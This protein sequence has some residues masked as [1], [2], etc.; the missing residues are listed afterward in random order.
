V[1]VPVKCWRV[2]GLGLGL[3]SVAWPG[4]AAVSTY[5][6]EAT[7][8]ELTGQFTPREAQLTL[9]RVVAPETSQK[10]VLLR[11]REAGPARYKQPGGAVALTVSRSQAEL[12][13][14]K[15]AAP[16]VCKL[17]LPEFGV[18]PQGY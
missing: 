11:L 14:A 2:V 10:W 17:K 3:L 7:Q 1:Q 13:L 12:V 15:D 16:L 4:W 18:R 8:Q 6:C 9:K 5:S